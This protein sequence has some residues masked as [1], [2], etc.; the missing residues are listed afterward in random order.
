MTDDHSFD[1]LYRTGR[2]HGDSVYYQRGTDPAKS[3]HRVA[4]TF[5]EVNHGQVTATGAEVAKRIIDA[6]NAA[7]LA[8]SARATGWLYMPHEHAPGW[9]TV[10]ADPYYHDVCTGCDGVFPGRET[11]RCPGGVLFILDQ[12]GTFEPSEHR[13]MLVNDPN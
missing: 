6:L 2:G 10:H 13:F 5:P 12:P 3:D 9:A 7:Q 4:V 1:G 11:H 8:D